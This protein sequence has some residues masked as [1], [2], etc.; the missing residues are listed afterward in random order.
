MKNIIAQLE[1]SASVK[2]KMMVSCVDSILSAAEL[3]IETIKSGAKILLCGNGG[4]AADSQHLAAELVS[5]LKLERSAIPAIALTTNT[6]TL[7]AIANDYDFSQIF[8]RQLE[9]FGRKN[10]LLIGISTSGNSEDVLKTV[11]YAHKNGLRTIVMT[12]GNGGDLAGKADVDII[13]PSED[14]QRIQE[15]HIT[16]GHILCDILEQSIFGNR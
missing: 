12:G 10:D 1:D 6:S 8:V 16:V 2:R 7:T 4:S 15:A 14:V 11:D 5:K 3:M 9:A 13:V